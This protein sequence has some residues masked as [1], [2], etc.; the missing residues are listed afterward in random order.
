MLFR[1]F[2]ISVISFEKL[3]WSEHKMSELAINGI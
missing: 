2:N 3:K 1:N